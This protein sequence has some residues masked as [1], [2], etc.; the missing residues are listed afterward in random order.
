M[1]PSQNTGIA[2][3]TLVDTVTKVSKK[4]YFLT[5]EITPA[6]I[7]KNASKR[8][9]TKA[10]FSDHP[11]DSLRIAETGRRFWIESPK[12]HWSLAQLTMPFM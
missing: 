7:P 10:S 11:S 2:T 8:I 12:S 9:A 4:E 1:R 3:S 5:A 6:T